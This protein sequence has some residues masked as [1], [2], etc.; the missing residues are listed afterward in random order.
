MYKLLF[1]LLLT[2]IEPEKAHDLA[3]VTMKILQTSK[4]P[5]FFYPPGQK[6]SLFGLEFPNRLGLAAGMDKNAE[7][8]EVMFALG[9]GHVEVGTVTPLPQP[10]N[11]KPR[12]W[13]KVEERGIVNCMGFPSKG[14]VEVRKNLAGAKKSG[15]LGVNIGKNKYTPLDKAYLD[16]V[17]LVHGLERYADYF[18]IN[19]SSPNT[20]GLRDMFG[21]RYLGQLVRA[22]VEETERPVL[23]KLS[24][25][26][27]ANE[28]MVSIGEAVENGIQGFVATNTTINHGGSGGLSGKPLLAPAVK[29]CSFVKKVSGLPVIGCGGVFGEEDA[30]DYF[31]AGA[32]L[33]QMFTGLVYEGP[34][35]VRK[36]IKNLYI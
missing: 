6:I 10:G 29:I 4:L 22:V 14:M 7:V 16:Y 32:D 1:K 30:E 3:I 9:F 31:L 23:L 17:S 13:R 25:D 11:S 34:A 35:I 2:K 12:I 27:S 8:V 18:V 21:R 33:V 15:V 20:P 5:R 28:L 24:P 19:I 26:L 36:I